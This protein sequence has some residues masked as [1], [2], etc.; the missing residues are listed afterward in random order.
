MAAKE[1]Q[2]SYEVSE[3]RACQVL[4]QPR[5]SQR[6]EPKVAND[7]GSLVWRMLDLARRF[8]R[9]GYRFITAKLRQEGW[10]AN[11]KRAYQLWRREGLKV[12]RKKRRIGTSDNACVRHRA[13]MKNDV[14][15]WD[16]VFDR[17]TNGIALKWPSIVDEFT[18][19]CLCLKV[20]RGLTSEDVLDTLAELFATRG[21]P[22]HIR[23]DRGPEFIAQQVLLSFKTP[24]KP[25]S[26]SG[27][28]ESKVSR[29][30]SGGDVSSALSIA[31][32]CLGLG[33]VI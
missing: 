33:R 13:R 27:W 32:C 29:T 16:F 11:A 31:K 21:V 7:E 22:R 10:A 25:T 4:E 28:R 8:P 26:C 3:R 6:D 14:W 9:S 12:L 20:D 17:T 15:Y 2:Q 1:L 5:S 19:E 24:Y 23:S 30:S 18:R